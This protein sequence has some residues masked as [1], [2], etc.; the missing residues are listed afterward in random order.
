MTSKTTPETDLEASREAESATTSE[1]SQNVELIDQDHSPDHSSAINTQAREVPKL[2]LILGD[3]L[4]AELPSLRALP[5]QG[6][7]LMAEVHA[8][9]SYVQHHPQ[10]IA[11]IF[12]AMRHFAAELRESGRT[13]HYITLDDP[14]NTQSICAEMR[15]CSEYRGTRDW[16][17]TEPGEWRLLEELRTLDSTSHLDITLL[18]DDRFVT[19]HKEFADFLSGRKQPRMEHFY[20]RVRRATGVLMRADGKPVGDQWNFDH[21]NRK[22]FSGPL[23]PPPPIFEPDEI[24]RTVLKLVASRFSAHFGDLEGFAWPVTRSEALRALSAFIDE[25]LPRFGDLQDAMVRGQDTL[26]HSLLS[27]S[28]NL[29]LLEPLEVCRA[30]ERAYERGEAPLNAVE[31]FIRQIIGWREYVRGLYWAYMPDYANRD[32]LNTTHPLPAFYWD[33]S[34]TDMLCVS[35]A[36]RNTRQNAYAHHIQRLMITGNFALLFGARVS[37]VC[38]WYLAVYIDAFEWVELPNTLGMALFG[39]D[40]VMAS[41]PYCASGKY[42]NRMSDYCKS[43]RYQVSQT[44]GDDACPF[45]GLYWDF[46]ARHQERLSKNPRMRLTLKHLERMEPDQLR[47][48]QEHADALRTRINETGSERSRATQAELF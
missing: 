45:N 31:G 26:Y 24:T 34:R 13:V 14:E 33:E 41:K 2:C 17:V 5:P 29:G 20:R 28:L 22:R 9:A 7:I 47:A 35:E 18:E 38:A 25:R 43:C 36:V 39:D 19:T 10:K 48:I 1:T 40:G 37:E 44:I 23:P 15:R 12:S 4:S 32:T 11:L 6:E 16:V 42:I 3:Q 30:A 8:E 27:A 46:L 21:D